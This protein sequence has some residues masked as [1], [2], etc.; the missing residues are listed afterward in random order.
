LVGLQAVIPI[1]VKA[2]IV[3]SNKKR[4]VGLNIFSVNVIVAYQIL[5]LG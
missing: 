4:F 2:I 5:I 3:I 1:A